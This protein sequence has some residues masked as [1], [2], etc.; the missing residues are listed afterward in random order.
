MPQ[1]TRCKFETS[2][3]VTLTLVQFNSIHHLFL[4]EF[5]E[6]EENTAVPLADCREGH[7]ISTLENSP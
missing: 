5:K 6:I 1:V 2:V 7:N 3:L 4:N